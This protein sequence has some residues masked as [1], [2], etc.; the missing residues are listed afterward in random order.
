MHKRAYISFLMAGSCLFSASSQAKLCQNLFDKPALSAKTRKQSSPSKT[1]AKEALFEEM[2][3]LGIKL[4]Y[5]DQVL[6]QWGAKSLFRRRDNTLYLDHESF[7]STRLSPTLVHESVHA[8]DFNGRL[9][10]E[11]PF[12]LFL[13]NNW[14][15]NLSYHRGFTVHEI[16]AYIEELHFGFQSSR[17]AEMMED[18]SL[19]PLMVLSL[20]KSFLHR[21]NEFDE[22]RLNCSDIQINGAG[23]AQI[24]KQAQVIY[25]ESQVDF[26]FPNKML[27]STYLPEPM[28]KNLMEAKKKVRT[29]GL[30]ELCKL[31]NKRLDGAQRMAAEFNKILESNRTSALSVSERLL[32]NKSATEIKRIQSEGLDFARE[33]LYLVNKYR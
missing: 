2:R 28:A 17:F 21:L 22:V 14:N 33:L 23:T 9:S 12:D 24:D 6:Q 10:L 1:S 19:R 18:K 11:S 20:L 13:A 3:A 7:T 15:A 5:E 16:A 8:M 27:M 4:V 29:Q 25:N 32:K 31:V 30:V 26:H